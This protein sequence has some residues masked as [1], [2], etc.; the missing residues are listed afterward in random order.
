ME[1]SKKIL[2]PDNTAVRTALWRALHVQMDAKPYINLFKILN[3]RIIVI[4]IKIFVVAFCTLIFTGNLNAQKFLWQPSKGHEQIQIWPGAVPDARGDIKGE[5]AKQAEDPVASK[6]WVSV[7]NVEQPTITVYKPKGKNSGAAIIVFPGGGYKILAIDLEGT[8]IC[9]WLASIGI[10][11]IL[12]KYRVPESG[13]YW[14]DKCNCRKYPKAPTALEDAQRAVGLVRY[15]AK[16]WHIDPHK[17]GVIGFSA[18]GHLVADVSNNFEKR[19]YK[20][21]D[22]ADNESCR[23]DFGMAMYPGHM[24]EKTKKEFE[25]NPT[26]RVTQNTPPTF[27]LQAEDDPVDPVNNS[28]VYYIA[29]KKAGV[30]V[31]YHVYAQGGHGFGLRK[32]N[33]PITEWPKLAERWLQ[34]IGMI[35]EK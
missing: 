30:K 8:E 17:I 3:E 12:L 25:L 23:P 6:P 13:S 32:T 11:G 18:G 24:M 14:D 27:I 9:E 29:L 33:L 7:S 28:L 22:D 26:I 5:F 1:Q 19:L 20:K 31:E 21:V 2:E 35:S 4:K 15:H 16:E 10:T 34:T